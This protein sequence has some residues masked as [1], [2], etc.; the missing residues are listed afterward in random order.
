MSDV[1]SSLCC[2]AQLRALGSLLLLLS[3]RVLNVA[4]PVLYK[5]MVDALSKVTGVRADDGCVLFRTVV[6]RSGRG[7]PNTHSPCL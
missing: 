2:V 7:V 4:V 6:S 5:H 3:M 1:C